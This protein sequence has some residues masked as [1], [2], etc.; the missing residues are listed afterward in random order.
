MD[1]PTR[2]RFLVSRENPFNKRPM[3]TEEARKK[4]ELYAQTHNFHTPKPGTLDPFTNMPTKIQ[5]LGITLPKVTNP[6]KHEPRI[7]KSKASRK[8]RVKNKK[9]ELKKSRF[10][11]NCASS[12]SFFFCA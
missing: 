10:A 3:T 4:E 8:L 5:K 12:S 1:L 6:K 7:F 9:G 11:K 2:T